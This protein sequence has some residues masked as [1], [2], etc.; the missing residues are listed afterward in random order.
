MK[1]LLCFIFGVFGLNQAR[2]EFETWVK[3]E[4]GKE[5]NDSKQLFQVQ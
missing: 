1:L 2:Y 3:A 5:S 4:F